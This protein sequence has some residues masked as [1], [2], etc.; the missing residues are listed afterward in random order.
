MT[1]NN[2]TE[3]KIRVLVKPTLYCPPCMFFEPEVVGKSCCANDKGCD[4]SD[5]IIECKH[6]MVC[7]L[8]NGG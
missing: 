2:A 8:R 7:G 6:S 3:L 4:R 1:D 5:Y